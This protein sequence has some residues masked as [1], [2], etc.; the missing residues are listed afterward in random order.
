MTYAPGFTPWKSQTK[1]VETL[2]GDGYVGLLN[3]ATGG[4]KTITSCMA[5]VD[6]G[7]DVVLIIAPLSTHKTAWIDDAKLVAGV[8]VRVIGNKNKAQNQA[9]SDFEFGVPGWYVVTPQFFTRSKTTD[10]W[11]GDMLIADEIHLLGNPG[12]VG[13]RKLS[14]YEIDG[15][16]NP[17]SRRFRYRLALSATPAR[18][19]FERMWS[20]ARFLHPELDDRDQV[21]DINP[22][23]WKNDRMTSEVVYTGQKDRFGNTKKATNFLA[24]IVPGQLISEMPC[25]IQ[26]FKRERCCEFHPNGFLDLDEPVVIT[27]DVEISADQKRILNELEEQSLAWLE[28]NPLVVDFPIVMHQRLRQVALGVPTLNPKPPKEDGTPQWDL[29]YDPDCKSPLMDEVVAYTEQLEDEPFVVYVESQRFIPVAIN[30][31]A[32]A[33][34]VAEEYSG[35]SKADLSRF[36]RDYQALVAQVASFGTGTDG[37]QKIAKTEVW[38]QRSLDNTTN[39]Q[40]EGRLDRTGQTQQV[41]RVYFSDSEGLFAGQLN[42]Q[43]ESQLELNRSTRR[44]V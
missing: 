5:A 40:T 17:I 37:A 36:G 27:R 2:R 6:S 24:E 23:T 9:L 15:S 39:L 16:D 26:H 42:Q 3:V 11:S 22:W 34:I 30:K 43:I 44:T 14:G 38:L 25:V 20:V 4:G 41:L 32:K 8:A 21:A 12:S 19:H 28:E 31:L 35:R 18:N 1:D 10:L 7:A 13:Q 33:G 29:V